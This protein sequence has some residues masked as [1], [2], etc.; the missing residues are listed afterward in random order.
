MKKTKPKKLLTVLLTLYL[1][2]SIVPITAYAGVTDVTGDNT[3]NTYSHFYHTKVETTAQ[4]T[5]KDADGNVA[6]TTEVTKSGDFVEGNFNSDAV[7][8]EIK[9]IDDEIIAQFSSRGNITTEN[10]NSTFILDHFESSNIIGMTPGDN[11]LVDDQDALENAVS[12]SVNKN[13]VVHQ[14]QVYQTTYDLIVQAIDGGS[15][16]EATINNV[17]I[18]NVK[19]AYRSG[20]AP[21]ATAEVY[22]ADAD[23]YEIDYECWQEM[24][25]G[26]P[27][28]FWYSDES[29]YT[30]SMKKITQFEE[31]KT[32]MYSIELREKNGYTFAD[33]CSVT[34]NGNPISATANAVKTV[35]GLFVMNVETIR[36]EATKEISVIEINNATLTFKDGDKP[37]FTGTV[38]EN[39]QY[40]FRCEWWNLDENTGIVST[41]PEWGGDIYKNKITAFEA[42]KTYHYGVYVT[43]YTADISPDAK[44]KINGREVKYTRIGDESDTQS[45]WVE[46]DLTMTPAADG[47]THNYG[48][49][50]KYDETNHW[51]ECEDGEKADITAHNFK[52]IVDKKATATEKGSKHEECTVCGYKKTAVDIPVTDFRNSSDDQPNKPTNTASSESSS[53]DQTNKPINTASPKTGNTDNMILWIVLLVIGG[54]AFITATAVDRKKK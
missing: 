53:A 46:T 54:G 17:C 14:Y 47:H 10:R 51:H 4:V 33:N 48:T 19:F 23:K 32:Y 8:A 28:A 50:W 26:E 2:L 30:P 3:T 27:V 29:K 42:G 11:I 36:P 35:D 43:A 9:R 7:Q 39:D 41:E 12:G 1:A 44:L 5:I 40:A 21:Q 20:D 22:N 34:I 38:P 13:L 6:E 31:G 24:E 15:Q 37:V 16:D 49:E 25:N 18:E 45:F 52:W